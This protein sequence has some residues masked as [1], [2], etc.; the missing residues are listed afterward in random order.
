MCRLGL[1]LIVPVRSIEMVS[2]GGDP[3]FEELQQALPKIER[4]GV[5]R[6]IDTNVSEDRFHADHG[7]AALA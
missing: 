1:F 3:K 2:V 5:V 4:P 7:S 6:D